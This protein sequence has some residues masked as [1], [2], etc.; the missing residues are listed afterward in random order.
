M[1]YLGIVDKLC[2]FKAH[3]K[4]AT[5]KADRV[6]VSLARLMPNV[7]G[8]RE[9]KRRLLVSVVH[10]VLLYGAPSWAHTLDLVPGN[11]NLLNRSQRK[12]LLR[13]ICA[14]RTVSGAATTV[15]AGIPPAD[16]LARER[17]TEYSRRRSNTDVTAN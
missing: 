8:P 2:L 13:K 14:Y 16:L 11:V 17:E 5:Q 10:S 7:G 12:V 4:K 9:A 6:G 1:T 3:I 15:L